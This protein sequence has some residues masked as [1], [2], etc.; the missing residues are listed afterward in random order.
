MYLTPMHTSMHVHVHV[1][2]VDVK[3]WKVHTFIQHNLVAIIILIINVLV[4]AYSVWS[5]SL[6]CFFVIDLVASRRRIIEYI[7]ASDRGSK[8]SNPPHPF[9]Q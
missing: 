2:H 7:E 5:S 6:K 3:L 1:L 8:Y 9:Y 4:Q